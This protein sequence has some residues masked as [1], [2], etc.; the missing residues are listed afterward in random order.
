MKSNVATRLLAMIPGAILAASGIV[1]ECYLRAISAWPTFLTYAMIA[2]G[3]LLV[4]FASIANGK[5]TVRS[6][7]AIATLG[8]IAVAYVAKL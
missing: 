2:V 3:I 8:F 5:W 4:G 6:Y 1:L 7:W